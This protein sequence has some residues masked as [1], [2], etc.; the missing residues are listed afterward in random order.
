MMHMT[1]NDLDRYWEKISGL[2]LAARYGVRA[3]TAPAMQPWGL[4]I[5]YVVDPTGVLWHIAQQSG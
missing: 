5:T 3:P 2:D 1:V 4:V